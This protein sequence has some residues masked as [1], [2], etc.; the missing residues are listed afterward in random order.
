[1][2]V[3]FDFSSSMPRKISFVDWLTTL[4][5]RSYACENVMKLIFNY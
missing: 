4:R 3:K 2:S 5:D 1:M